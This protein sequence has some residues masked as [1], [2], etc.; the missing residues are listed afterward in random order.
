[1][2]DRQT[3]HIE[4]LTATRDAIG[5]LLRT[6]NDNLQQGYWFLNPDESQRFHAAWCNCD[7]M[8]EQIKA[9]LRSREEDRTPAY[10]VPKK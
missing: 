4:Q 3:R 10:L 7:D 2:T 1:M 5:A 6:S 8:I 9:N